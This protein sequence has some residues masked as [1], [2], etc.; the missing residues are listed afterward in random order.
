VQS[1]RAKCKS[2]P[3]H[4]CRRGVLHCS[5]L[6]FLHLHHGRVLEQ[7]HQLGSACMGSMR[8]GWDYQ[9]GTNPEEPWGEAGPRTLASTSQA[10]KQIGPW[11]AIKGRRHGA[12][13]PTTPGLGP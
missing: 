6:L 13:H 11:K 10:R 4:T 7:T 9:S 5:V 3:V 12:S 1:S 8:S 2:C